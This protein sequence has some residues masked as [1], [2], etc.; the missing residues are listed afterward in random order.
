MQCNIDRRG[1]WFRA[2]CGTAMLISGVFGAFQPG[3]SNLLF[4]IGL[5]AAGLFVLFEA[6]KGWCVARALGFR[7]PI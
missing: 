2:I 7:T 1:R 6:A 3:W 5:A 4:G